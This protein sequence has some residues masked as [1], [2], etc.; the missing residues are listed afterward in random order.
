MRV[1]PGSL[2]ASCAAALSTNSETS[3]KFL[4]S[5]GLDVPG[6]FNN[7]H[8]YPGGGHTPEWYREQCTAIKMH[9]EDRKEN[10]EAAHAD[11][12]HR[13]E[14]E[15][16]QEANSL[17][18]AEDASASAE[19][20]ASKQKQVVSKY[21]DR[22][23]RAKASYEKTK[24]CPAEL[25]KLEDELIEMEARPNKSEED[26]EAE[27]EKKKEILRKQKCV[28]EYIEAKAALA[29][30][31]AGYASEGSE[32]SEDQ[33]KAK[34]ASAAAQSQASD[35][36]E[37]ED[38]LDY[39]R[40]HGPDKQL[41]SIDEQCEKDMDALRRKADEEVAKAQADY[42]RHSKVLASKEKDV[43][44]EQRD[45]SAEKKDVAEEEKEVRAAEE[46]YNAKKD[47]PAELEKAREELEAL[48]AKPNKSEEDIDAECLKKKDILEKERCVEE[49]YEAKSV[50]C[51]AKTGYNVEKA[52]LERQRIQSQVAKNAAKS[53]GTTL[54][55][56]E[57]ALNAAKASRA[58]LDRCA[59]GAGEKSRAP[60]MLPTASAFLAVFLVWLWQ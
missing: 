7:R 59:G 40:S 9:C 8:Y 6:D 18:R 44:E 15:Y 53:Y 30:R 33:A 57:N 28:D 58:E 32:L 45:V 42:D 36:Q 3:S 4:R 41:A 46:V 54:E 31:E 60:Q 51:Q 23:A 52:E 27:C 22:V 19:S 47:C 48:E 14:D 12:V 25:R 2:L 39:A 10:V 16:K 56:F 26:I 35:T 11:K 43:A 17:N 21:K 55:E 38:D 37:A 1:I 13:L 29:R 5:S 49:F 24:N 20:A 50:L 34:A